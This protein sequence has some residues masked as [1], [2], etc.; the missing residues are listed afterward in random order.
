MNLC[1]T[2]PRTPKEDQ[3]SVFQD[4]SNDIWWSIPIKQNIAHIRGP[5]L[6]LSGRNETRSHINDHASKL[7]EIIEEGKLSKEFV[8]QDIVVNGVKG[9]RM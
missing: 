5:N 1:C 6:H 2:T 7:H 9:W 4:F 3:I 8:E